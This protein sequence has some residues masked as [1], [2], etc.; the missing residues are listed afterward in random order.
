MHSWN[1]KIGYF[2]II[3]IR[4]IDKTSIVPSW[5]VVLSF[6]CYSFAPENSAA[7][8]S[9]LDNIT[10]IDFL[11]L[12]LNENSFVERMLFCDITSFVMLYSNLN[13]I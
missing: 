5:N 13:I 12:K 11:T 8:V 1:L 3:V 10:K 2:N 9:G 6:S 7:E 4:Y